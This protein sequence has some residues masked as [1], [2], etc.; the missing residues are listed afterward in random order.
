[1]S[2]LS[3]FIGVKAADDFKLT[4]VTDNF[5]VKNFVSDLGSYSSGGHIICKSGGVAMIVAP[6]CSEIT[7]SWYCINDAVLTANSCS[8]PYTG[9]FIPTCAQL[10]LGYLC[11]KYWDLAPLEFLDIGLY[12][13]SSE[14]NTV[15]A[16]AV[17]LSNNASTGMGGGA[18]YLAGKSSLQCV[19]AF[20]CVTY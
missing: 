7:R 15:C 6:R 9:W 5:E 1:M 16:I 11:K 3:D 13:S 20:R 17:C 2:K 19:R 18:T 12:W 10:Q 4:I 14:G 8:F